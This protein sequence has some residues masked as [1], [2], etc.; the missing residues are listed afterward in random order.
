MTTQPAYIRNLKKY[1]R[2]QFGD[3]TDIAASLNDFAAESDRG[4]IILAAT[5]IED[6]LQYSLSARMKALESDED[7]RKDVFDGDGIIATYSS[8][9]LL[10]Y[11]LG[12]I[13]KRAKKDID[14]VREIRNVCAHSRL[15]IS[16]QLPEVVAAISAAIGNEA[17]QKIR[18]HQQHLP[19]SEQMPEAR[20]LRVTFI[21]HCAVL[22]AYVLTGVRK[23]LWE[24]L[25]P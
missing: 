10:A 15:P 13:D 22:G 16:M 23:K 9:I 4:A 12:I 24:S 14:L 25:T 1:A 8:K 21:C 20:M 5:S 2:I 3:E 17:L 11:A 18:D 6:A 19:A 7:A